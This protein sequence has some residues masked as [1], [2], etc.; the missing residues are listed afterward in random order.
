MVSLMTEQRTSPVEHGVEMQ[1]IFQKEV[2]N[3]EVR[4]AK[5]E[6]AVKRRDSGF[7]CDKRDEIC[8]EF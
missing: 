1:Y 2:I 4:Q 8:P 6:C 5:Y 7:D 3:H